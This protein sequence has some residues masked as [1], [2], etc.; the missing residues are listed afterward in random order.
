MSAT[1]THKLIYHTTSTRIEASAG[2][3][4]T[5]QLASRY[6]ALLMLGVDP[7]TIVALTFTRKAAGEFRNRILH[8]LAEGACD[9]RDDKTQRNVLASRIWQVWSGLEQSQKDTWTESAN[10]IPLLPA[11]TPIVKLAASLGKYPEDLYASPDGAELRE[12][13]KLPEQS[14][15]EF[16]R[17]LRTMVMAMSDLELSTIDSFFN[18]LVCGNCL[19]LGVN[20]VSPLAPED[21]QPARRST[22]N[23]YLAAH[24]AEKEKRDA[25]LKTF[26]ELTGGKGGRTIAKLEQELQNHLSL[27]REN[28]CV[29]AWENDTAFKQQ[30]AVNFSA[31]SA[32]EADAWNRKAYELRTLLGY[33]KDSD[34]EQY[35][36]SGLKNISAQKTPLSKTIQEWLVA[37]IDFAGNNTL[38]TLAKELTSAFDRGE[39]LSSPLQKKT[40]E[41]RELMERTNILKTKD[42]QALTAIIKALVSGKFK[43]TKTIDAFREKIAQISPVNDSQLHIL[44]RIRELAKDLAAE[45]PA[46][47]LYDAKVRTRSLYTLLRDYAEAYE[48]RISTTGEFSFD[49]IA[50]K[51][52]ELMTRECGTEEVDNSAYCREHLAIRTGKKYL[53]WMLDEFQDTSDD[54]FQTLSPALELI[55][56]DTLVPFTSEHPRPLPPSLLPF[57]ED[58]EHYVAEGSLF[59]VG[60]EKQGIYGF[61]TGE[62]KSFHTLRTDSTWSEPVKG[63]PLTKSY[64]SATTIMGEAGFVNDVFKRLHEIERGDCSDNAVNLTDFTKHESA[65]TSTGY[66]EIQVVAQV[67]DEETNEELSMNT[68]AYMAISNVLRRLTTEE[69]HP[70]NGMSIGILTRTNTEA[71]ALVNHLRNDM[72]K[73]PVLLVKDTLSATFCPLGEMLHHLF[74]WLAHPHEKTSCSILKASFMHYIFA[75]VETDDQAWLNLRNELENRGYTQLLDSIL[76]HFPISSLSN[77]QQEA[78]RQVMTTWLNTARAF[79]AAGGTLGDWLRRISSLST[80]GVAS[81]RYVQV[82]TMHKSKGLEF[83]AVILPFMSNDAIDSEEDLTYF[84]SADG[85]SILLSPGN[86]D[87]RPQFWPGAFDNQTAMW[88]QKR[89]QEA[90]NLFYVAITRAKYANYILVNG[91]A[92]IDR[93]NPTARARSE[94]GLI[95]R[96]YN[97]KLEE[98]TE[99]ELLTPPEGCETW[100]DQLKTNDS[101]ADTPGLSEPPAPLGAAVPRRKRVSPSTMAK[102]EDKQAEEPE[103]SVNLSRVDYGEL[104]AAEFGKLVHTAWEEIIWKDTTPP[105]N[106][107]EGNAT[108]TL[109]QSVVYNA[110]Q[111]PEI[112]ALFTSKPSQEVYNEQ[113]IEAI[114]EDDEW[115]SG[116]IDRLVLTVDAQGNAI[117]AHIIDFKTNQLDPDK[118]ESYD[119]LKKEYT[120]QMT[121]YREH[122]ADALALDPSAVSVSLLS[123]P[124]GL[125]AKILPYAD[126]ELKK[127]K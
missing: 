116:T 45:L 101:G 59:V 94:S 67:E 53:H 66:V 44:G 89:S 107:M 91:G 41:A 98:Y 123:C 95:R 36:Y 54:Q 73:L 68:C 115:L 10:N 126:T 81:S 26:A 60:D 3:G 75:D 78:H 96:A 43:Q 33:F 11:T 106:W 63:A 111:Q 84:R 109:P 124:L 25:F 18:T 118:K 69:K 57:H 52:R 103:T 72:P 83:D 7:K 38:I 17:L 82:M 51:A 15:R 119:A 56:S 8:A 1:D 16:A 120:A 86:K 77:E 125:R 21:E 32:D 46:K 79:D 76:S 62:S 113:P 104:T 27:Y 80:Q 49:D 37:P 92:L 4:K 64:R 47:C 127:Q 100:Y 99:T 42:I 13:L 28:P 71:E 121:A 112:A 97:G 34:F 35:V 87:T 24:T 19:E 20:S 65:K 61:R 90:Y 23:D 31:L 50:R 39:V 85:S 70:I 29:D 40:Q 30:C 108:R 117:A 102:A 5:Y 93:G 12:Y 55:I 6:I 110:L 48:Q 58:N 74:R 122:V 114:T 88:K 105:P 9:V 22:I 2:T 14:P